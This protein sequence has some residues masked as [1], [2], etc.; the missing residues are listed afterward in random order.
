MGRPRT[1]AQVLQ[2]RG[3]FDKHPERAREDAPGAGPINL[4]PPDGL[5][6]PQIAA[7]RRLAERLPKVA[8]TSTE[9]ISLERAAVVYAQLRETHPSSPEFKKLDDSLRQ[10]LIQ[11]GMTLQARTKLGT[12][13]DKKPGNKF[14]ELR[15]PPADA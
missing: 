1:P 6:G 10:W 2:L 12:S 15:E 7:W 5:T 11:L 3:A 13:G 8:L 9:E 4:E 14:A